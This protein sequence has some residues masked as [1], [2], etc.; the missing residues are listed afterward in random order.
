MVQAGIP[1]NTVRE[2]LGHR[3]LNMTLR[4]AHL[5]PAHQAEAVAVLDRLCSTDRAGSKG[6]E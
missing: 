6:R 5:A 3:S 1:L 2:I 4:Y